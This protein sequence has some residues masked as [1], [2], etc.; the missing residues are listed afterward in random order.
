[1]PAS[2]SKVPSDGAE[3]SQLSCASP[4]VSARWTGRP[5]VSTTAGI[6]VRPLLSDPYLDDRCRR[7]CCMLVEAHDGR[8]DHLHRR[9]MIGGQR[10]DDLI[11]DASLPPAHEAIVTS[12]A[13]P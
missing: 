4:G 1:V 8:I 2:Q 11:P 5:L 10:I 3:H 7:R 9:F 13:G 12:G 6:F